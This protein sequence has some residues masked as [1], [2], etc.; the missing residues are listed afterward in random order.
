MDLITKKSLVESHSELTIEHQCELLE[1]NVSTYYYKQ[2]EK[3][4]EQLAH[5]EALRAAIDRWHTKMPYLGCRRL[6]VKLAADGLKTNRKQVKRLMNEM[7]IYAVY[8]KPNLSKRNKK[9]KIYP[10]LLRNMHIFLPNQVW[11][12]DITYIK[13]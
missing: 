8:P 4:A 1:L 9:H 6:V 12:I 2:A 5:E 11:A 7:G 13:S 10:Y 3:S